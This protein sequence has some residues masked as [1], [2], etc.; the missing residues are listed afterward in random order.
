MED[1]NGQS[2]WKWKR[3]IR[4][5]PLPS[6]FQSQL[7]RWAVN[8]DVQKGQIE[9]NREAVQTLRGDQLSPIISH[10]ANLRSATVSGDHCHRTSG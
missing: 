2:T 5:G 6:L 9:W 10:L 3:P 7:S 4:F 1:L 8:S